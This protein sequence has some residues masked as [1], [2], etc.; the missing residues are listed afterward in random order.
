MSSVIRLNG[1]NAK[2]CDSARP[3]DR[4]RSKVSSEN[5][6]LALRPVTGSIDP[7]FSPAR[8]R[9]PSRP[10]TLRNSTS[11]PG[12]RTGSSRRRTSLTRLKM[13][14]F[15]PMPS[16]EREHDDRGEAGGLQEPADGESDI[17]KWSRGVRRCPIPEAFMGRLPQASD[18][19]EFRNWLIRE[20]DALRL[21]QRLSGNHDSGRLSFRISP[22]QRGVVRSSAPYQNRSNM[23]LIGSRWSMAFSNQSA[24]AS[25]SWRTQW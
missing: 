21:S 23:E 17:G 12:S 8:D 24:S 7:L 14:V 16:A 18:T 15:A 2:T 11:S 13:A 20:A 5:E 1:A 19:P 4:K 9:R 10:S 6:V 22:A 3:E 25:N